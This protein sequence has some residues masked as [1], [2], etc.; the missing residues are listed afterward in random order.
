MRDIGP[1]VVVLI[2]HYVSWYDGLGD[3]RS[4]YLLCGMLPFTS[5]GFFACK[6]GMIKPAY[7]PHR[8]VGRPTKI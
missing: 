3:S 8:V 6:M 4:F 1:Q 5:G 2:V 7:L